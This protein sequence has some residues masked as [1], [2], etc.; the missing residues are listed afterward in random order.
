MHSA[1]T[2]SDSRA[3][4]TG[5]TL[6]A[7]APSLCARD[8]HVATSGDDARAG[9]AGVPFA[10]VQ[11]AAKSAGPGDTVFIHGGTYRMR[12]NQISRV[13]ND[14]AHVISLS[15]SGTPGKPIRFTAFGNE[16]PVFDLSD[17][18]P[19]DCRVT[20]FHVDGSWIHLK[21]LAVTG[22]Q[23]T[24]SGHTQSICFDNQG[25]HNIYGL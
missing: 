25:S 10:T 15:R 9:T 5:L 7:F 13:R 21:G 24:I 11:R 22:V 18:K 8:F 12:E 1:F 20:A 16:R 4:L 3:I 6:L 23:V 2:S 14:R 19:R 17:V